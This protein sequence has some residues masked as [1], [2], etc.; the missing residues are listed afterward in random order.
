MR[1]IVNLRISILKTE[2]AAFWVYSCWPCASCTARRG[3]QGALRA[4]RAAEL[5]FLKR[6]LSGLG[7]THPVTSVRFE[8]EKLSSPTVQRRNQRPGRSFPGF[9]GR[10]FTLFSAAAPGATG[11]RAARQKG[12]FR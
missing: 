1:M 6:I 5:G 10:F 12:F 2:K 4:Q 8:Q 3:Q 7:R 9:R 11:V